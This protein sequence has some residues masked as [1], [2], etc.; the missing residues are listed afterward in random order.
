M[1]LFDRFKKGKKRERTPWLSSTREDGKAPESFVQDKNPSDN[2]SQTI[3]TV[4]ALAKFCGSVMAFT[5]VREEAAMPNFFQF[6]YSIQSIYPQ[7]IITLCNKEGVTPSELYTSTRFKEYLN[8]D[9]GNLNTYLSNCGDIAYQ[10]EFERVRGQISFQSDK[11]TISYNLEIQFQTMIETSKMA[12]VQTLLL[13]KETQDPNLK[14]WIKEDV[15]SNILRAS[16]ALQMNI[17]RI[18]NQSTVAFV[19]DSI[20]NGEAGI[21]LNFIDPISPNNCLVTYPMVLNCFMY[22][23]NEDGAVVTGKTTIGSM[24]GIIVDTGG[25]GIK[26]I[27]TIVDNTMAKL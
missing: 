15:L 5:G 27:E 22:I 25:G 7:L 6:C 2:E 19:A 8:P 9:H 3:R 10:E 4:Y 23:P 20:L 12:F 1:G 18:H 16:L 21:N 24:Q 26:A 11:M 13:Y 17:A 14:G